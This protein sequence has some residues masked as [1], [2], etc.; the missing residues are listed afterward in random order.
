MVDLVEVEVRELLSLYDFDGDNLLLFVD[1][2]K[3]F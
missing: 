2:L 1:L 3:V